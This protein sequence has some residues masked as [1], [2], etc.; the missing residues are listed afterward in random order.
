MRITRNN[1]IMSCITIF[2]RKIVDELKGLDNHSKCETQVVISPGE[3]F[4]SK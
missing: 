4:V 2:V 1:I 3:S